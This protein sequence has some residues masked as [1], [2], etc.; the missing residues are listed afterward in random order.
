MEGVRC[1]GDM[2]AAN[3][4]ALQG[5]LTPDSKRQRCGDV[6]WNSPSCS[7]NNV[8]HDSR[9]EQFPANG[10][11]MD[12]DVVH[13]QQECPLAPCRQAW[14]YYDSG[15]WQQA[16]AMNLLSHHQ[17]VEAQARYCNWTCDDPLGR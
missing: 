12:V 3:K 14:A 1:F 17:N 10:A 7:D 6:L 5:T 9:P 15:S 8:M 16:E 2:Q 13:A 11:G 4:R